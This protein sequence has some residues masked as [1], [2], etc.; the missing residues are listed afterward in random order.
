MTMYDK[1]DPRFDAIIDLSMPGAIDALRS[2]IGAEPGEVVEIVTPQFHRSPDMPPAPALPAT[3][4]DWGR[5]CCMTP[6]EAKE[7]G[8]GNW[9]GGLFLFPGDWYPYIPAWLEVEDICG[10]R[11]RWGD[12][13]RDDDIRWGSLAYGVRLGPADDGGDDEYREDEP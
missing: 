6:Q 2:A 11:S 10:E 7:R 12:E 9:D 5:L 3:D 13:E 8:F 4:E 1:D